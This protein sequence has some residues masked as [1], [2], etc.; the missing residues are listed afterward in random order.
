M[1]HNTYDAIVLG[2]GGMGSAAAFELGRRGR[3]V[4][5]LEQ[6]ALG[7]DRGSSHGHTRIIRKAYFEHP[8]YV[9][10]VLRAW[11]RW[12]DLERRCG[13]TLLTE[14]PCLSIGPPDGELIA[15]VRQSAAQHRLLVE[16]LDAAGLRRR[17]PAFRFSDE[18]VGLVEPSAGF[19]YVDDCV[20][21]HAEEARKLGAVIRDGE[22]ATSWKA[23]GSGVIVETTAGRYSAGR[24]IITAGPW[25]GRM[26]GEI[27]AD[28]TVMRQ[29]VFWLGGDE[30]ALRREAFPIFIAQ[31]P[32]GDFYG[33]PALNADGVKVA[34]HYGVP[35]LREPSQ[36]VRTISEADEAPVRR[37][38]RAHLPA[39]DGPVRRASTCIYTLT[40]DRH[41]LIDVHPEHPQVIFAAGFSGHGFKFASVMGEILADLAE[42]GRTDQPIGM[43][44]LGRLRSK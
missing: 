39:A 36:I 33:L 10:L 4:L 8:D 1:S 38:V 24:L 42:S 19:L 43:F 5:G 6:F 11:E 23:E 37:F 7:H 14:H 27:G 40:A 21:A 41:F 29:V 32:D 9:P 15:G 17:Y 2:I 31:T 25:A 13:R 28:L 18:Y 30:A 12:R 22:P 44:R 16:A 26:L 20:R 35:E 34:R 3:R